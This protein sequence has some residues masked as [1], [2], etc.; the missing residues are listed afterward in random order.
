MSYL[1]IT[2]QVHI[3]V[4]KKNECKKDDMIDIVSHLHQ[5]TPGHSVD[6]EEQVQATEKV[7]SGGDYLTFERHKAAQSAKADGRNPSK[8]LQC[9]VAKMEDFHA[10]AE[11]QIVCTIM[12]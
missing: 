3:G 6:Q 12:S 2:L 1:L 5:Y 4:L 10:Q 8:R 9:M 11:W 7:L